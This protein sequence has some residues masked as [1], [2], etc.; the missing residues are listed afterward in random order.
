MGALKNYT[1]ALNGFNTATTTFPNGNTLDNPS[2]SDTDQSTPLCIKDLY[3]NYLKGQY[4][5][6]FDKDPKGS[7]TVDVGAAT[8]CGKE[9]G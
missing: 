4:I 5:T 7:Q 2:N 8:T 1:L 3:E 9:Q 6:T